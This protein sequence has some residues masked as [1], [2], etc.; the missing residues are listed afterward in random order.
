MNEANKKTAVKDNR[1]Y[2]YGSL[3]I[4]F[5]VVFIAFVLVLNLFFSSLSLKGDLTVDLTQEEF[6][7]VGDETKTLL[8]ALGKDL[9]ITITFMMARDK[10]EKEISGN[11]KNGIN[12]L[13][14]IRDLAENY[15]RTFDGSGELG[16]VRV[17]YKELDTD[18]TFEQKVLEE[19]TTRLSTS[20]VI[21]AGKHH[22]RVLDFTSFLTMN[23][24]GALH[25]FNGEYRLTSAILQSSITDAQVV[26]FTYGNGE[27]DIT[28][29]GEITAADS[30]YGIKSLLETAGFEIK[31]ANLETDDIDPRTEILITY[32]PE[33]DLTVTELK[34]INTYLDAHNSYIVFVDA[35]TPELKN[36]QDTLADNWGINYNTKYRVTDNTHSLG[37]VTSNVNAKYAEIASETKANSAAY[38]ICK[39]ASDVMGVISTS[40][41]ESVELVLSD[42]HKGATVETILT[43]YDTAKS[44]NNGTVGSEGKEMPLML[45]STTWD[46]ADNGVTEYSY[47][48]LVGSTEFA[49]TVELNTGAYGNKRMLLSA[50]R[51]F[52]ANRVAPDIDSVEFISSALTIETGT[53]RTLTWLICTILPG[54][55]LIM[56][57]VMF[58]RRRHL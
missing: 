41:P 30:A 37:G 55:V 1:R 54:A 56:G 43:S 33:V 51:V 18:P 50:A 24:E 11:S 35:A 14:V 40:M 9:D 19:T 13:T 21:V 52:G 36:L 5:T 39:T 20:S 15:A 29:A 45:L 16:T 7:R 25:S 48:M 57:I 49:E 38:Q 53:A 28:E 12:L 2:K 58:F 27:G 32:D 10:F 44:E 17:E 31:T 6:T 8:S 23:E 4:V 22:Y 46:Y 3:S 47:V 34:K 26:T 42:N